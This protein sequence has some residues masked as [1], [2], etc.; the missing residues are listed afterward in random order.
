MTKNQYIIIGSAALMVTLLGTGVLIF[1]VKNAF[2]GAASKEANPYNAVP[3]RKIVLQAT[4]LDGKNV[5]QFQQ[6]QLAQS[7]AEKLISEATKLSQDHDYRGAIALYDKSLEE[8]SRYPNLGSI[9]AVQALTEKAACLDKTGAREEREATLKLLITAS[10]ASYNSRHEKVAI[11][12]ESLAD[13]LCEENRQSEALPFLERAYDI[14]V[15]G[16]GLQ[17]GD[18]AYTVSLLAHCHL[19]LKHYKQA[20]ALYQEAIAMYEK[21]DGDGF[22]E[23]QQIARENQ[24]NSYRWQNRY[25][26]ARASD[27]DL[28]EDLKTRHLENSIYAAG[29]LTSLASTAQSENDRKTMQECLNQA[30][31]IAAALDKKEDDHKQADLYNDIADVYNDADDYKNELAARETSI[32]IYKNLKFPQDEDQL[33]MAHNLIKAGACALKLK[34]FDRAQ[35]FYGQALNKAR[36]NQDIRLKLKGDKAQIAEYLKYI[37]HDKRARLDSNMQLQANELKEMLFS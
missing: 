5:S 31:A 21:L 36:E 6:N 19:E 35:D 29:A 9:L 2:E 10:E 18:T 17:N 26:E 1:A 30:S 4:G 34:A 22:S 15:R 7:R 3:V 33:Q 14:R 12:L 8:L 24:A 11:A 37:Q 23:S 13:L 16:A 27:L 28:L 25:K 32:E 20:D